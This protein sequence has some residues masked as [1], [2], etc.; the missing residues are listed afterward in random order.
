MSNEDNKAL[1]RRFFE[2]VWNKGNLNVIDELDSPNYVD[3]DAPP[4]LPA[5]IEGQKQFVKMY[6]TAFPDLRITV[7]DVISE[8]DKVVTRWTARGTHNGPLMEIPK[9]GK[10]VTVT[11]IS[12]NRVVNGKFVEGWNSFD[13][14]SLLQQIGQVPA[15]TQTQR[16]QGQR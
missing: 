5:G 15:T 1:V 13:Q 7:D 12:E 14:M 16:T 11:G 9:T 10:K 3:H 6:R 8:G 2:E 4:G